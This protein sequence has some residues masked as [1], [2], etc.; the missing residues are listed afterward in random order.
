MKREIRTKARQLRQEGKS[1]SDIANELNISRGSVSSW[2]RDIKLTEHQKQA[3]HEKRKH[4]SAQN[5]G[6]QVNRQQARQQREFYQQRGREKAKE[7]NPLHM[8]GCML[9]WAEGGKQKNIL[10]FV[11]SDIY[12][13]KLFMSFLRE[14]LFV[15]I[16]VIGLQLHCH[17]SDINEQNRMKAF[18]SQTLDLP[19]NCFHKVQVKKGSDS[20]KNRLENGICAIRISRTEYVM[21]LFGAIQEYG[22]FDNPDWLF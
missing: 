9:Y 13:M 14:E 4:W 18:W 5:K 22:R 6:A 10:H 7:K 3:L 8:M 21:H 1:I 12:M 20:R 19:M 11:N 15:P 2:C 17:T 16:E